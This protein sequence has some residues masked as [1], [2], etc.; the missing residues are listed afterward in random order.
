LQGFNETDNWKEAGKRYRERNR[1]HDCC[2]LPENN[3]ADTQH[4]ES[5]RTPAVCANVSGYV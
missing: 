3:A 1:S 5:V 2:T 4:P